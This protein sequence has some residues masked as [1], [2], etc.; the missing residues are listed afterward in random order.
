VAASGLVA[1]LRRASGLSQGE[2]AR[3]AG[4]SRPTLSAYEHRRKS[5]TLDTVERLADAADQELEFRP[6]IAFRDVAG[7]RGRPV[8]VPTRLPRLEPDAALAEVELP[9][10]VNW[11]QPGRV[12]RL[13]D[14]SD[15]AR[16]YELVL[17]EGAPEDILRLVD[18]VLLVELWAE[19]VLPKYV[20][21]AWEPLIQNAV[22]G[23]VDGLAS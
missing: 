22:D 21:G 2:L 9:L 11:S 20:R 19:L 4:T 15:R 18:G 1:R 17:R 16:L 3:R 6:R 23:S 10:T 8:Q 12:F 7:P 5:P 13:A 14:R